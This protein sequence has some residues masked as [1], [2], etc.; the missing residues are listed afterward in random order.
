MRTKY[1]CMNKNER[2]YNKL[3]RYLQF[4]LLK[5]TRYSKRLRK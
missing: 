2:L 4:A 3:K 5:R 1:A